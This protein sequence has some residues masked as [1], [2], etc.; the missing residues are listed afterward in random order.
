MATPKIVTNVDY[1]KIDDA[2]NA[3]ADS[4]NVDLTMYGN[5]SPTKIIIESLKQSLTVLQETMFLLNNE[6]NPQTA[7]HFKSRLGLAAL[8]NLNPVDMLLASTGLIVINPGDYIVTVKQWSKIVSPDGNDYYVDLAVDTMMIDKPT[9][10]TCKQGTRKSTSAILTGAAYQAIPLD[11]SNYVDTLSVIATCN[12]TQLKLGTKLDE[13]VDAYISMTIRGTTQLLMSKTGARKFDAGSSV[14]ID[15]ADCVGIYGDLM[16]VNEQLK[17]EK[18]AFAGTVDVTNKITIAVDKPIIGGTDFDNFDEDLKAETLLAG[19]NNLI[20]TEAQMIQYVKRFKQYVVQA[21]KLSDGILVLSCIRSVA[22]LLK[23]HDYWMAVQYLGMRQEDIDSLLLHL[24]KLSK[25][26][27]D[28]LV[29]VET[30]IV[31]EVK[32]NVHIRMPLPDYDA[33]ANAIVEYA[34]AEINTRN[35]ETGKLYATILKNVPAIEQLKLDF[36]VID[37]PA[38]GVATIND[39]GTV[40]PSGPDAIVSLNYADIFINGELTQ[41]GSYG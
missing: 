14:N 18:F 12:G 38:Y 8:Q 10:V 31:Q 16:T 28:L 11:A 41:F 30:A 7:M 5:A 37:S 1:V 23:I 6:Q 19:K 29:N 24:N 26:S 32:V 35:F 13:D 4:L 39:F 3:L 40:E 17:G 9:Y 22:E 20:G 33:V 27:L 36:E 15:Y 25:K 34:L 2:L 21:S